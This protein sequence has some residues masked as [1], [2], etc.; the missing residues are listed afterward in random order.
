MPKHLDLIWAASNQYWERSYFNDFVFG[1]WEKRIWTIESAKIDEIQ[2]PVVL[3]PSWDR[4]PPVHVQEFVNRLNPKQY[5]L[6]HFGDEGFV[7]DCS[8]YNRAF[9]AFR[10]YWVP[11][12]ERIEHT[13]LPL[14]WNNGLGN[15]GSPHERNRKYD[16]CFIGSSKLR[17]LPM[18][19]NDRIDVMSILRTHNSFLHFPDLYGRDMNAIQQRVV[20]GNTKFGPCTRGNTSIDTFRVTELLE[21]GCIP[22]LTIYGGFNYY[23][24]LFGS[25]PLPI[26][27]SWFEIPKYLKCNVYQ[28][29]SEVWDWYAQTKQ[30]ILIDITNKVENF[31]NR[32]R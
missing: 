6:V 16:F 24:T 18:N 29:Q 22:I 7:H 32:P 14:G 8:Y 2:N 23:R 11:G 12:L 19:V 27:S 13:L 28:L 25:N 17:H 31:L 4:S 26:V 9:H 15:D 5:L 1:P 3:Y 21:H 10:N 20:Y 30:R